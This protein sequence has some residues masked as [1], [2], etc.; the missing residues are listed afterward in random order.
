[1]HSTDI[2]SFQH[3]S[4]TVAH[5]YRRIFISA[6]YDVS[7]IGYNATTGFYVFDVYL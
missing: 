3:K 4:E 2:K 7:L 5:S 6:G 1:M